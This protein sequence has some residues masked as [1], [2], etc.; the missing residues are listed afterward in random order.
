LDILVTVLQEMWSTLT[1][2]APYLLFG[3]AAAGLLSM[4]LSRQYVEE[5][6]GGGGSLSVLKSALLGVPLPLC[7]CS[8]L[9]V[10]T[11]LR[12][13]GAG[14]GA[15]AAFLLST[16]QTGIDSMLV[17]YSLLGPVFAVLRP[18]AA[19]V[20]GVLGGWLTNALDHR[21][22]ESVPACI[23]CSEFCC[24]ERDRPGR[25]RRAMR[26]GFV[27]LPA[28]I[29]RPM[30]VGIA[31]AG[32]IGAL[33]PDNYFAGW[34][35]SG[36]VAMLVMLLLGIPLYVCATA[37]VPIAAALIAKGVSPGAA[38]VFLMTGP[39]TNAAAIATIWQVLGKR[40]AVIYLGTVVFTALTSGLVLDRILS[41]AGR[42]IVHTAHNGMPSAMG[43]VSG[44][45]LLGVLGYATVVPWL[46]RLKKHPAGEE[47]NE[48]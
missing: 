44:V 3:F 37:S 19:F 35:D 11:S 27:T 6:L 7:S 4:F 16:P 18:L 2:M 34:A 33:V 31:L 13:H 25:L 39:A 41:G 17:T 8:V 32:L 22:G 5:H 42:Q 36:I 24:A 10:A 48:R 1:E 14:R 12:K 23:E 9:P 29:G 46:K 20:S 45:A 21:G 47:P 38:L 43:P 28:D 26:H 40:T 30:I 15:T